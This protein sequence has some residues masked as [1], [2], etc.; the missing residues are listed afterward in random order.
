MNIWAG[1]ALALLLIFAGTKVFDAG[2]A[3]RNEEVKKAADLLS[4]EQ[5]KVRT[6]QRA[7]EVS[8]EKVAQFA[9]D[10]KAAEEQRAQMRQEAKAED[11]I[12]A[13]HVRAAEAVN[14]SADDVLRA[15]WGDDEQ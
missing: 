5:G 3:S 2:S 10:Q 13:E 8:N 6:L 14:T 12:E 15:Y 9:K 1:L 7:L 4:A 11:D